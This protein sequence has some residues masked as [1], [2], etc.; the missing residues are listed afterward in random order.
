[1]ARIDELLEVVDDEIRVRV[2]TTPLMM[3]RTVA[4]ARADCLTY[5]LER[6]A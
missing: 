6:I 1:M 3:T 4:A 2:A 5:L